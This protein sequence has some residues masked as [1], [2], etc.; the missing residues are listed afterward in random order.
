MSIL[1]IFFTI[2][3]SVLTFLVMY[4]LCFSHFLG[5]SDQRGFFYLFYDLSPPMFLTFL[6]LYLL[7]F[8]RFY[9]LLIK[10]AC[11]Y[12][13]ARILFISFTIMSSVVTFLVNY[14]LRFSCFLGFSNQSCFFYLFCRFSS[15]LL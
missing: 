6:V 5:F 1:F 15:Y 7:H 3:S 12:L 10:V 2:I 13:F 14:L 8:S 9:G 4:L 11:F